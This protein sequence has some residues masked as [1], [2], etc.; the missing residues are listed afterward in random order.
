[1]PRLNSR[2]AFGVADEVPIFER[3]V[4]IDYSGA[5]TPEASLDGLRVFSAGQTSIP[6]EVE[7]P[8]SPHKYW[9]RRG[10]AEWLVDRLSEDV[11]TIVG[12]DH[13]FS[14]PMRYFEQHQLPLDWAGF[15]DDFQAH[16]PTDDSYTY[17]DFVREGICGNGAAR[18]GNRRWRRLTEVRAG[19]AKSVFH[20]DVPGAVAKSTHAGLPWLRHLRRH[21]AGRVHF[22]PFDGWSIAA[23]RSALVEVYPA[24]WSKSFP[25]EGRDQHQHDAY[26]VARWMYRADHENHLAGF[27]NPALEPQ[28]REVAKIEGWI[29]GVP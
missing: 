18:L 12:V 15:L 22:W 8:P 3:Y 1:M 27:L 24:L 13:G 5:R 9:T 14:F 17:V 11:P 10:I 29:L 19:A 21:T 28:E 25:P 2:V 16:W 7:P 23:G 6:V 20:F 4:G 26:S